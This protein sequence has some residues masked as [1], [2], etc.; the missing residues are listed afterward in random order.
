VAPATFT[1]T[2]SVGTPSGTIAPAT[3]QTVNNGATTSFTLTP[4]AGYHIDT[5]GGTC[6]GTL[7]G[8]VY[9]T[10]PATADCTVIANFAVGAA[11]PAPYCP[12]TFPSN[13]EPITRVLFTGID[14]TSSPVVNATPALENFL[15]ITGGSVTA[16]MT[17]SMAVEGNT[18][19]AYTAKLI[20]YIDWNQDGVFGAGESYPLSDLI[21]SDGTDGQ[22]STGTIAVPPT[23]MGGATRMRVMKKFNSVPTACNT[24]GFGQAEDY[25]LNVTPE[26][27]VP[28]ANVSPASFDF[29][30]ALGSTG[31]DTLVI[32]NTGTAT[33]TYDIKRALAAR[34]AQAASRKAHSLA[35]NAAQIRINDAT[36]A[37][38]S[39]EVPMPKALDLL[40]A[41][42]GFPPFAS[43]ILASDPACDTTVTGMISHDHGGVPE[44]GYGWNASA[45]ADARMADKFT[46]T[47][48]PAT[49][50][51]VCVSLL[52]NTGLTAVPVKIIVYADDGTGGA[53]GTLLGSVDVTANNI[54][55]GLVESFQAFDISSMNLSIA[56]GSVYIG[57]QWDATASGT[58]GLFVG[59]D[60]TSA[61]AGGYSYTTADGAWSPTEV[62][63]VNYKAL[64][65][66]AVEGA[67]GPPGIGC[68]SPSNVP[69][70]SVNPATGTV[71]PMS[72]KNI[73]LTINPATLA[74]GNYSGLLCVNTNDATQP[75]IEVPVTLQVTPAP[76]VDLIFKDGFDGAG[77]GTAGTYTTR[78]DF[79]THVAAGFYENPFNDATA[80]P[81]PPLSYTQGAIAYT[82]SSSIPDGTT[83]GGLYN[84]TGLIS[85]NGSGAQIVVT[86]TGSPV[87]AVGGNF[88]ATDVNV[89][90]N[91]LPIVVTLSDGTTETFTSTGPADFRGFTT[92]API[93]TITID[94]PNPS[95]PTDGSWS[96]MDNLIVGSAN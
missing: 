27:G 23:A 51:T 46:P 25:T 10:A 17:Y 73:A 60:E 16:G 7:T 22:Q 53:P 59:A 70:L 21:N 92:A 15:P 90:A 5:V 18:D 13:V 48:Y 69:W 35:K 26:T 63:Q 89:A 45:G 49:F 71:S 24:S 68:D 20:V 43:A 96:A 6:G 1:V 80:G 36:K 12:V 29:T 38:M 8:N 58:A 66:R 19:G 81:S 28:V 33:L 54:G 42:G 88:W 87:T 94:A 93:T 55:T 50:S 82:V 39:G 57:V 72:S 52:T 11:F 3:A 47:A 56:S 65:I 85:T 95:V 75:R 4:D 78:A 86:F 79:L 61:S 30:V 67:G 32:G 76:P 91:G 37:A 9:T 77:G 31:N 34:E 62:G 83:G 74:V 41:S 14:N 64:Y 44:N 84:D 40:S 2:P